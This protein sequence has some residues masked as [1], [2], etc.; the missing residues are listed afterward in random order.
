MKKVVLVLAIIMVIGGC[1]ENPGALTQVK[2][3]YDQA[4]SL[5]YGAD[6]NLLPNISAAINNPKV[7][8]GVAAVDLVLSIG[9]SLSD[10]Y[11]ASQVQAAQTTAATAVAAATLK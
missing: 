8:E 9:G 3:A 4:Q 10:A 1:C 6:G 11:C 7:K 5:A 2:Q